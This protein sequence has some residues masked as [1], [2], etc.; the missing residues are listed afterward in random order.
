MPTKINLKKLISWTPQTYRMWSAKFNS[1][2]QSP[3]TNKT[4]RG[5][6]FLLVTF[7][8]KFLFFQLGLLVTGN[9]SVVQAVSLEVPASGCACVLQQCLITPCL[10]S[11]PL[12]WNPEMSVIQILLDPRIKL[13]RCIHWFSLTNG[14]CY[15][16]TLSIFLPSLIKCLWKYLFI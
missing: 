16:T 12:P 10:F 11:A 4:L 6:P 3:R 15:Y 8:L 14:R 1:I 2:K 9:G 13:I 5:P 7:V